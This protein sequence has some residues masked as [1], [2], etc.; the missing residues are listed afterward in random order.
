M[1][2]TGHTSGFYPSVLTKARTAFRRGFKRFPPYT[3][4]EYRD[5]AIAHFQNISTATG[6]S[7]R[8]SDLLSVGR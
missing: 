1:K 5:W 3:A 2:P 6:S 4:G 8:S 7:G